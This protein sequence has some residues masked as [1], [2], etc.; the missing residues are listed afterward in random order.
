M[1][2]MNLN[3]NASNRKFMKIC[4]S[5]AIAGAL[6]MPLLP[7]YPAQAAPSVKAVKA[8]TSSPAKSGFSLSED[9]GLRAAKELGLSSNVNKSVTHDKVTFTVSDFIYDGNRVSFV[10]TRKAADGTKQSFQQWLDGSKKI[11][12]PAN[13]ISFLINDKPVN[14]GGGWSWLE[15]G[16]AS[17][18]LLIS[19]L[20]SVILKDMETTEILQIPDQFELGVKIHDA[21]KKH[22]YVIKIPV[23][24][25]GK[26]NILF[27]P[28]ETKILGDNVLKILK[29]EL[30]PISVRLDMEM[31]GNSGEGV[32]DIAEKLPDEYKIDGFA[33]IQFELANDKGIVLKPKGA[34]GD[35]R[36]DMYWFSGT[37]EPL[38]ERPKSI[39]VKPYSE[40]NGKKVYIP[41]AEFV[42][43][44]PNK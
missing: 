14:T 43:A 18:S 2:P 12:D 31:K 20:N 1:K 34:R 13:H 44:V 33:N 21:K 4:T 3:G 37:Y 8:K 7:E 10:L 29:L 28:E 17:N 39:T 24:K 32:K 41:K 23:K 26:Q 27:Q 25:A 16:G 38:K 11:G 22:D 15:K 5:A 19:T 35:G 40:R 30:S 42:L 9:A 36:G 6:I